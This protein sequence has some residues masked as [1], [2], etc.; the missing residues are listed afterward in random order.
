MMKP[1]KNLRSYI[2][3]YF[4]YY[5]LANK[6]DLFNYILSEKDFIDFN[7][8]IEELKKLEDDNFIRIEDDKIF[9]KDEKL[10]M[11][12]LF[13]YG[14]GE[15]NFRINVDIKN[16]ENL[17]FDKI[18]DNLNNVKTV[19]KMYDFFPAFTIEREDDKV[20]LLEF[21]A[22]DWEGSISLK[23]EHFEIYTMIKRTDFLI[24]WENY[25]QQNFTPNDE[26]YRSLP[27]SSFALFLYN[28][29]KSILIKVVPSCKLKI[30]NAEFIRSQ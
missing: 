4:E 28:F 1:Q 5:D 18:I 20:L 27:A 19:F 15:Y 21:L 16:I 11:G 6:I 24:N 30:I 25:I 23:N 10:D 26:I 9:R 29:I 3:E 7:E 2:L 8:F 14:F 12:I 13:D 17:D 22:D